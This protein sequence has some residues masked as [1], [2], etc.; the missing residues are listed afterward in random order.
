MTV[1]AVLESNSFA[2]LAS[3][4]LALQVS[5]HGLFVNQVAMESELSGRL[6]HELLL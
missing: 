1:A 2:V 5:G 4:H 3:R 6:V